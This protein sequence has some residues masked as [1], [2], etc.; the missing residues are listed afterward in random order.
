[1]TGWTKL[2]HL[3]I[4]SHRGITHVDL[5]YLKTIQY[6]PLFGVY[7]FVSETWCS[8][9]L[10]RP[11]FFEV[12]LVSLKSIQIQSQ[13]SHHDHHVGVSENSVSLNPMVLLIII[14]FLNG[15]LFQTNPCDSH[16]DFPSF[17]NVSIFLQACTKRLKS[18]CSNSS[19]WALVKNHRGHLQ[20]T[21]P[22]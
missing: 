7:D 16:L 5:L 15:Y 13:K 11:S 10:P 18:G 14:P 12:H 2:S 6:Y 21:L 3:D 9:T 17:S 4:S 8:S 22:G 20:L 1:M 19:C